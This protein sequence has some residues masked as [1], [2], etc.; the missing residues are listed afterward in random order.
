MI[1]TQKASHR[2]KLARLKK[3]TAHY[4]ET[5]TEVEREEDAA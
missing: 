2:S 1:I 3:E 4:Y 5:L